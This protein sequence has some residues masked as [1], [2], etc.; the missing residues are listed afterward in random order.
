MRLRVIGA[1]VV[2]LG[3]S[4]LAGVF[5]FQAASW[6]RHSSLGVAKAEPVVL[7]R[8]S[9][10]FGGPV[11]FSPDNSL[12]A[13]GYEGDG[14]IILWRW[15]D[16]QRLRTLK[17]NSGGTIELTFSPDG[18]VLAAAAI[19]DAIELWQVADGKRIATLDSSPFHPGAIAFSPDGRR[20]YSEE[21][22]GIP[23]QIRCWTLET[24]AA[25]TVLEPLDAS[26]A[27]LAFSADGSSF[28]VGSD[29]GIECYHL[30]E[31][32]VAQRVFKCGSGSNLALSENGRKIASS[33]NW[34]TSVK[35]WDVS[36]A[37]DT[38]SVSGADDVNFGQITFSPTDDDI[39]AIVVY[40]I[41]DKSCDVIFYDVSADSE[42]AR[43]SDVSSSVMDI[44]FSPDGKWL[45]V[46]DYYGP[47]KVWDTVKLLETRD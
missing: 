18:R 36:T 19:G 7:L 27:A 1:I 22:Y 33:T 45:A 40:R 9:G 41:A 2:A 16:G 21:V 14:E 15:P 24:G 25:T 28:F 6:W 4:L 47:V 43:L 35:I 5:F 38:A 23:K 29:K 32:D 8:G 17:G 44:A 10:L 12:L 37:T 42:V 3:L 30:A 13:S 39:L 31:P 20:L 11:A 26:R 34:P 46:G